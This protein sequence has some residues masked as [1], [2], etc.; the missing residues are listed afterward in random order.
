MRVPNLKDVF[1][2]YSV[3][4]FHLSLQQD[5]GIVAFSFNG[6]AP[7]P[8]LT[9][10]NVTKEMVNAMCHLRGYR[11]EITFFLST[12]EPHLKTTSI[13]RQPR[14]RDHLLSLKMFS[15]EDL[16]KVLK[17]LKFENWFS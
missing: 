10:T 4:R 3:S 8:S 7:M 13:L 15:S 5:R 16:Y 2:V 14:F 12:V 1:L 9:S 17:S 6:G 11:Y